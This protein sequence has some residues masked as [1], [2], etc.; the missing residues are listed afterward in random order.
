MSQVVEAPMK[1][2]NP[3]ISPDNEVIMLD[4]CKSG[5]A[6]HVV[7]TRNSMLMYSTTLTIFR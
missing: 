1:V 7:T 5:V 6:P 4:N 3:L 2:V